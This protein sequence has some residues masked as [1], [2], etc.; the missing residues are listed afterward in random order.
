LKMGRRVNEEGKEVVYQE[1]LGVLRILFD[2]CEEIKEQ[3]PSTSFGM[4]GFKKIVKNYNN[5]IDPTADYFERKDKSERMFDFEVLVGYNF[6]NHEITKNDKDA[7]YDYLEETTVESKS[8]ISF[9]LNVS[10]NVPNAKGLSAGLGVLYSNWNFD[11]IHEHE[12]LA[13]QEKERIIFSYKYTVVTLPIRIRYTFGLNKFKPF[14]SAGY[15]FKIIPK[16]NMTRTNELYNLDGTM[17]SMTSK[18]KMVFE[19]RQ[20]GFIVGVGIKYELL[21]FADIHFEVNYQQG[22]SDGF[23]GDAT[24][25]DISFL[26]LK[27]NMIC[28][29][30]GLSF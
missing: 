18:P 21:K 9:G 8:H 7:P 15:C 4:P 6:P 28:I 25:P 2:D 24:T 1:Y 19:S 16:N 13:P 17:I 23:P 5:C 11:A 10:V 26:T 12:L 14:V 20:S 30:L 29:L 22:K 3:I 27:S